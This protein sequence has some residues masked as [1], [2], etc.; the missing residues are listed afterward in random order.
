MKQSL[1][2]AI[3]YGNKDMDDAK[4]ARG[5]AGE[6]KATAEAIWLSL[7]RTLPRTSRALL[8]FI[9]IA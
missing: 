8:S 7:P 4:K 9:M 2:D 1:E 6:T 5:A 3:K